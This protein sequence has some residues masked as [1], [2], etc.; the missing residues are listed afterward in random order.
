MT[1]FEVE[2]VLF[3][4]PH[5][6]FVE[7]GAQEGQDLY[8]AYGKTLSG[9]WLIVFF[10]LKDPKSVLIISARDMIRKERKLYGKQ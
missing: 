5:I 9:R 6:R 2:E 1:V 10:V 4:K 7:K 8:S 3:D